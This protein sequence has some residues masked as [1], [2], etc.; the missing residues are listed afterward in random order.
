MDSQRKF[1]L[2]SEMP[3]LRTFAPDELAHCRSLHEAYWFTIKFSNR[4]RKAIEADTGISAAHMSRIL[5]GSRYMPT[6]RRRLFFEACGNI[7]A[8][9]WELYQIGF[10]V[11]RLDPKRMTSEEKVKWADEML[12]RMTA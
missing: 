6:H 2:P 4:P 3:K 5:E 10:W 12:E 11:E 1:F 9:Q 8:L 7:Y